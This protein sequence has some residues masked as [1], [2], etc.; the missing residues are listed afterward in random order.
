ME[1]QLPVQD[2]LNQVVSDTLIKVSDT[3]NLKL[4]NTLK[5]FQGDEQLVVK[6]I[7]EPTRGIEY[8]GLL[9]AIGVGI[10]TALYNII[11]SKK[12]LSN[13]KQLQSQIN[14]LVKLNQL[15]ERR[16]RMSVKP[17]LYTNGSGY[18][19]TDW[20]IY[21]LLFNRGE[22]AFYHGF[23]PLEGKGNFSF[24]KWNES[25]WITKDKPMELK[26]QTSEHPKNTYFKM[27]IQYSDKENY[28]YES[29]IEWNKGS[30]KLLETIEL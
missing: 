8:W 16:L 9:I 11:A 18:H 3:I 5:L 25:I 7:T 10:L 21:L 27:K 12:L 26:G 15:F 23:E 29:I 6:T 17:H 20:T 4:L 13:D 30:A 24:P 22:I 1:V 2:T 28:Q 19:G 14:E